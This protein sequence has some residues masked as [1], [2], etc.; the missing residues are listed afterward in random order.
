MR[1]VHGAGVGAA[2]T[3]IIK[4]V[5]DVFLFRDFNDLLA[6]GDMTNERA[7]IDQKARSGPEFY[8]HIGSRGILG[9]SHVNRET[10]VRFDRV[11]GGAG[12]SQA[13]LFLHGTDAVGDIRMSLVLKTLENLE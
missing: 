8:R 4:L 9:D 12:A 1:Q 5:R 11:S 2:A 3:E 10:N 13:D 6:Q 7:V